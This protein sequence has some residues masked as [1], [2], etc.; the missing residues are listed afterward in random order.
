MRC[1]HSLTTG[2]CAAPRPPS[3]L[4]KGDILAADLVALVLRTHNIDTI[5]HFAGEVRCLLAWPLLC[6]LGCLQTVHLLL[7]TVMHAGWAAGPVLLY[8]C[9]AAP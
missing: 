4:V 9:N 2:Y 8:A 7:G 5:M 3:R 6:Y 1:F